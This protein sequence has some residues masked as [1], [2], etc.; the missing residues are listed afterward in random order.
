MN[1]PP[2]TTFNVEIYRIG[3]YGGAGA[4]LMSTMR[5]IPG[6]AQT[7]LH[8]TD[9][10]GLY[11]CSDWCVST[12]VDHGGVVAVGHVRAADRA[13]TTGTTT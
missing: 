13:P 12:S 6:T 1:S 9:S 5:N 2:S 8:E 7:G 4:R 11:E 3:Y 10:T